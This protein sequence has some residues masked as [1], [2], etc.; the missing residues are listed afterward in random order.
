MTT[1]LAAGQVSDSIVLQ[2][3]NP[4]D[5][6]SACPGQDVTLNCTIV[7][8]V[9]NVQGVVQ[10]TLSLT[11]SGTLTTRS[12]GTTSGNY[13]PSIF[14]AVFFTDNYI[15]TSIVTIFSVTILH[16]QSEIKCQTAIATESR[17]ISV[18]GTMTVQYRSL[19]LSFLC[20]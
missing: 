3:I 18:A 17:R 12:D 15:V 16:H 1:T 4:A 10:P 2:P 5:N 14:T 20:I 19:N 8:T 11:Y 13:D 6:R 7:R 9:N